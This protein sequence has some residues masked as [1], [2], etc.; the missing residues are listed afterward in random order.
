MVILNTLPG[1]KGIVMKVKL[2]YSC[3][4]QKLQFE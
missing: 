3:S 4:G 1:Q 2:T